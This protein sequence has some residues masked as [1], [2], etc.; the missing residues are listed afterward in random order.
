MARAGSGAFVLIG[1]GIVGL[2]AVGVAAVVAGCSSQPATTRSSSPS[3]SPKMAK[4]NGARSEWYL[5][6]LASP[7]LAAALAD[8]H[9]AATVPTA[10]VAL[11][12]SELPGALRSHVAQRRPE[13]SR[14]VSVAAVR[15]TR[16]H[17][18]TFL[19][20]G[21]LEEPVWDAMATMTLYRV[22]VKA[23]CRFVGEFVIEQDED[24]CGGLAPEASSSGVLTDVPVGSYSM[25]EQAALVLLWRHLGRGSFEY[26]VTYSELSGGSWVFGHRGDALAAVFL[27]DCSDGKLRGFDSKVQ[28]IVVPGIVLA[29]EEVV[30]AYHRISQQAPPP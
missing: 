5:P 27:G 8:A 16:L 21:M 14:T 9:Q 20:G 24:G 15:I 3:T 13:A 25:A 26:R 6:L 19:D 1:A 29:H 28:S 10:T 30:R 7:D 17:D 12:R 4:E 23:G 2:L 18:V 22:E 11:A